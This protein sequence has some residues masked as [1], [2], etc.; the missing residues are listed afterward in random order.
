MNGVIEAQREALADVCRR[1][2]VRRLD[3]FGSAV[4]DG[5]QPESSD[6]DFLVDFLPEAE[7]R[8]AECYLDLIAALR[9]LLGRDVDVVMLRTVRNPYFR[10]V[11]DRTRTLLYAA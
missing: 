11:I 8:L 3:L 10:T 1:F 4:G 6:F 2:K 9:E 7:P 5:F